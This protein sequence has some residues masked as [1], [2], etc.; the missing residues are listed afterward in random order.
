MRR[1][2]VNQ[3]AMLFLVGLL[4]FSFFAIKN[5][6]GIEFE[7]ENVT[8]LGVKA[9]ECTNCQTG[10]GIKEIIDEGS[11]INYVLLDESQTIE[12]QNNP[13]ESVLGIHDFGCQ[14]IDPANFLSSR[15]YVCST[16]G[17]GAIDFST[18]S[19]TS[20]GEG[21]VV[22]KNSRIEITRVTY[23]LALWLGQ[24]TYRDSNKQIRKDS[25]DYRSNGQQIDPEIVSRSLSPKEAISFNDAIS[26]TVKKPFVVKGKVKMDVGDSK[27]LDDVEGE[28]KVENA[29]HNPGCIVDGKSCDPKLAVSDYNV[30]K[31]NYIASNEKYGGY[32]AQQA[33]GGDKKMIDD[34]SE[35]LVEGEDYKEI[36]NG[37]V[38]SCINVSAII[39]GWFMETF[40]LS[41]WRRCT[42]GEAVQ[43][44]DPQTGQIIKSVEKSA[45]CVDTKS[46]G[47]KMTP[48]F[49]EPDKCEKELC[50]NAFLTQSYR[51]TLSPSE[52]KGV[53]IS[54]NPKTASMFFV[55]TD[56]ALRIDG[57]N[58]PVLCLWDA[59]PI[60]LNYKLQ[61]KDKA[62]DQKDFPKSFNSYW[63]N[64]NQAVKISSKIYNID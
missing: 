14:G 39:S 57:Q 16:Q 53:T 62:P 7:K 1:Q 11:S 22:S 4:L 36:D 21:V 17:S 54:G 47:I 9:A 8:T 33:P 40:G 41:A 44:T 10:E 25:P 32:L 61:E 50:A 26:D 23:P 60:L 63:G 37:V 58:V 43:T 6:S 31:S 52:S 5:L 15:R 45:E 59:S 38:T 49:G 34:S 2:R 51:E 56:C 55:A 18:G 28:Y 3:K 64:V 48:I 46:L 12:L 42:V 24:Y 13:G 20:G 19:A 30:G 27:D 29:P 35:C